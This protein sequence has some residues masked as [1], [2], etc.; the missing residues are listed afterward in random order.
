MY[1]LLSIGL[2]RA[3]FSFSC[4]GLILATAEL[5]TDEVMGRQS[6][7]EGGKG[8]GAKLAMQE[9]IEV[10]SVM[11]QFDGVALANM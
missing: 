6:S 3:S 9:K 5:A 2:G 10:S 8:C 1:M 7:S 11:L 4:Q